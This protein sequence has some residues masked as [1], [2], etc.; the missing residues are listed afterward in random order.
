MT[1][2]IIIVGAG[3]A[4]IGVA[5]TLLNSKKRNDLDITLIDQGKRV[6]LREN[7]DV[8]NAYGFAGVGARSD[9]KF[10]FE[11]IL[12]KRQIGSNLEDRAR[13][14]LVKAKEL[15]TSYYVPMFGELKEISE[16]RLRKAEKIAMIAGRNDIDYIVAHDYHI[17]TDR[18]PVFM[19]TIQ[20]DFEKR[21]VRLITEQ[22]VTDFDEK[23]V[24]SKSSSDGK[25]ETYPPMPLVNPE[26]SPAK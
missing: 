19:K 18:L 11:T 7:N 5:Y 1:K 26:P 20:D 6:E 8:D 10:I 23:A 24:Y 2:K 4:G 17:G 16:E 22:R 14:Y 9:G 13:E 25:E 3:P 21:G 15:F 12:G